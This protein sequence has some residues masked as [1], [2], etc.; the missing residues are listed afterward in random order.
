MI[1]YFLQNLIE[2]SALFN[3]LRYITFRTGA[4]LMTALILSFL[5]GPFFIRWLKAR[6]LAGQPIRDDGP[7][8]HIEEKAGTPTMGGILILTA[9][10][11]SALLWADL[12]NGYVWAAL[13]A[14]AGFGAIG[15]AD[16]ILKIKKHS[17]RG[18]SAYG[19]MALQTLVALITIYAILSIAGE[20]ATDLALPFFK[21]L[22]VP[23]GI[24]FPIF[25][26]FVIAGASNGVNLT[27]GLDGLAIVPVMIAAFSLGLITYLVGNSVFSE[28]LQIHFVKGAGEMAIL[29]GAMIGAGLGFLWFNAHPARIF[30]GDTGALGLGAGLGSI[31]VISKH[32][33]VFAII[34]GLFVMEALSVIMQVLS[35]KLTGRRVFQMAP[36]HHHL[37]K[38][39]WEEPTIV[40]RLWIIACVLAI[41][42]LS[43]LKLR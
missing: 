39:G 9:L 35:Y 28:Y 6:Q 17:A 31:A 41:I 20:G 11:S 32:E 12:S 43:T 23:L 34:G 40:V 29:C 10:F 7:P 22:T 5:A 27:D 18:I 30:M 2:E 3:V 37:E 19:K 25:A 15:L 1:L 26:L 8:R 38:K 21:N 42:G 16:D 36:F 4:A 24:F 33:I 14:I 13:F